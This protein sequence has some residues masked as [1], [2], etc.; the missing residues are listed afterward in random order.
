MKAKT[1]ITPPTIVSPTGDVISGQ[2]T[3][4]FERGYAYGWRS[5]RIGDNRDKPRGSSND[6]T[7]GYARGWHDY[8]AHRA[9]NESAGKDTA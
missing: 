2:P 1:L 7:T 4:D 6:I 5:G 9:R 8:H 3:L